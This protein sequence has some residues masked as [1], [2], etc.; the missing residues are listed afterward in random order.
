MPQKTAKISKAELARMAAKKWLYR[1]KALNKQYIFADFDDAFGFMGRAALA[2]AKYDHHPTW[3]NTY[4][5]V[6][7][8]LTTHDAG[9]VTAKDLELA[10][11]MDKIAARYLTKR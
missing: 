4:N 8:E 7:V 1:H 2:I 3:S 10:A 5:K 6:H 9:D 11:T